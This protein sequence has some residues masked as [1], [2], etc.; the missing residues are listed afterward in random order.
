M[1]KEVYTKKDANDGARGWNLRI[2]ESL[3]RFI[4]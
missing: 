3:K 2:V 4:N 1:H